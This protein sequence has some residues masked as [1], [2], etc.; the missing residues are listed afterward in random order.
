MTENKKLMVESGRSLTVDQILQHYP[1]GRIQGYRDESPGL[2]FL[3]SPSHIYRVITSKR[4]SW[5]CM[6][7]LASRRIINVRIPKVPL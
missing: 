4:F 2:A 5:I 1:S 6:I 3:W 7:S